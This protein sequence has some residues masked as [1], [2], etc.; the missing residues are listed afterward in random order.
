MAI[1]AIPAI[2]AISLSSPCLRVSV[3]ICW[4]GTRRS[5]GFCANIFRKRLAI[6]PY[7]TVLKILLLPDG[8]GLLKSIN[9]PA[10]GVKSLA[11]MGRAHHHQHAG[12]ANLQPAQT[13][14]DPDVANRE[15]LQRRLRQFFHLVDGHGIVS[16]IVEVQRCSSASVVAD[17]AFK[18]DGS[19]VLRRLQRVGDFLRVNSF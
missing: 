16:L 19:S 8:D 4:L 15:F 17:N 18:D 5:M 3:V 14:Y 6:G 10:A 13:V 11:A 12:L 1:M 2:L 9:Q 7:C